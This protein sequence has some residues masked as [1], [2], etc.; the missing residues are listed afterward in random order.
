MI[1]II[2]IANHHQ[3]D[4]VLMSEDQFYKL[5]EVLDLSKFVYEVE[6]EKAAIYPEPYLSEQAQAKRGD[7]V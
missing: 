6:K 1:K 4:N 2:S 5:L 7:S 3:W